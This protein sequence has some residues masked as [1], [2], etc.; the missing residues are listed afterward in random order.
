[1]KFFFLGSHAD[2]DTSENGQNGEE[3]LNDFDPNEESSN[4]GGEYM[5]DALRM[6]EQPFD[7]N[8]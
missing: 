2:P 1:M 5:D 4:E 8:I 7:E 3:M 6:V